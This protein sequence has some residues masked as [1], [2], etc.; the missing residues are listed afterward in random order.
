MQQEQFFLFQNNQNVCIFKT[1]EKSQLRGDSRRM[2]REIERE[3]ELSK[4]KTKY[5]CVYNVCPC[6]LFSESF[7]ASY[8]RGRDREAERDR[9][10]ERMRELESKSVNKSFFVLFCVYKI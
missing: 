2:K 7:K 4:T 10:I 9:E 8:K 1:Q 6:I 5:F 3:R